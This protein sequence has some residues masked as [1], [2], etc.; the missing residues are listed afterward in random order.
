MVK[1]DEAKQQAAIRRQAAVQRP[2][3]VRRCFLEKK[4]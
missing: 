1:L 2:T 3:V 4:I